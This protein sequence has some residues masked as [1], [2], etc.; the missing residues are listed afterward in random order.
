MQSTFQ[1]FS[2]L[3]VL[4]ALFG[5][6]NDRFLKL[7]RAVGILVLSLTLSVCLIGVEA[8]F[9]SLHIRDFATTHID[10]AAFP[11]TLFNGVLAFLM[12][13]AALEVS[14]SDL[15]SRK[16]TIA[17]LATVG[18]VMTALL[19]GFGMRWVFVLL[20]VSV[21]L[22][23]CLVL[24]ATVAPTDPVA[25]MGALRRVGLPASLQGLIAG[26]SLFNDG[27]GILVFTVLVAAATGSNTNAGSI[28]I[29]FA[30]EALGGG[31]LGLVTGYIA[32]RAMRR[33]DEYN[34]ELMI[35]LA[36]VT[37]T[38]SLALALQMSG[39]IA[40]VVAGLLIGTRARQL[41]MSE[42]TRERLYIV[43]SVIDEVLNALLCLII[44]LEI[45]VIDIGAS[46]AVLVAAAIAALL[47]LVVRFVS[48]SSLGFLLYGPRA[49]PGAVAIL[50]WAGLRGGISMALA[51]SMPESAY[52]QPLL[53]AC[54]AVVLF[55]MLVQGLTLERVARRLFPAAEGARDHNQEGESA[56]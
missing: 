30:R 15:W 50:T 35:S 40:V 25:V 29:D 44:G 31:V 17:V 36:L 13:A 2:A 48:V 47:S 10:F 11:R 9:P 49:R 56:N 26:E 34:V 23:W 54:Y 8:I 45:L 52:R 22:L 6:L 1:A 33:I 55:T 37:G 53:V 14:F 7:P 39:P 46:G 51:L 3:L 16:G 4:A 28:A 41:A 32:Y 43:W 42:R 38:Y 24:G 18:V 20:G 5:F 21:P 12:F 19:V 27:V